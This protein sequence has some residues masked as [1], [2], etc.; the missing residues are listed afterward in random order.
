MTSIYFHG[1]PLSDLVNDEGEVVDSLR[2]NAMYRLNHDCTI[3]SKN[4]E[5]VKFNYIASE[6][7]PYVEPIDYSL[8]VDN[9]TSTGFKIAEEL[10]ADNKFWW[11]YKAREL[12]PYAAAASRRTPV[13]VI[14]SLLGCKPC[15]VYM[16][17]IFNNSSF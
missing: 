14:Y 17:K 11:Y 5:E 4:G 7:D 1:I 8:S 13:L 16:K 15:Q 2:A 12:C 9:T 6:S 3:I 10:S